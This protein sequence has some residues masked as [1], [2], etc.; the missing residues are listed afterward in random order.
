MELVLTTIGV[1]LLCLGLYVLR[2]RV[3][4]LG[5]E[6]RLSRTAEEPRICKPAAAPVKIVKIVKPPRC[7]VCSSIL[8]H[9]ER[10][11]SIAISFANGEKLLHISGCPHCLYR[12][13]KRTCPVCSAEITRDEIL[14]AKMTIQDGKNNVKIFGCSHCAGKAASWM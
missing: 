8:N 1:V 6:T 11:K 12:E 5:R 2:N 3:K 10:V 13:E 7:P 4:R 14:T 9:G